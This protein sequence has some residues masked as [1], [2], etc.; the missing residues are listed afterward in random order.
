MTII[1]L[2]DDADSQFVFLGNDGA[3]FYFKTDLDA[4]RGRVIAINLTQPD[5]DSWKEI[6]LEHNEYAAVGND[7]E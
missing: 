3:I 7:G 5:R 1:R 4:P 2:L 6:I